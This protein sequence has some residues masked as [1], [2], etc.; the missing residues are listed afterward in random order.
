MEKDDI[1]QFSLA[2]LR[3]RRDQGEGQTRHDAPARELDD[4]FWQHA[5]ARVPR[6]SD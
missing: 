4:E 3:K 1:K 6:N 5:Q 2:N